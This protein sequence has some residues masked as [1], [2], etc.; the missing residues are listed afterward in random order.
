MRDPGQTRHRIPELTHADGTPFDRSVLRNK[1]TI[2]SYFQTWC[3]DCVREQPE[4]QKLQD[5]FGKDSLQV[6]MISDEAP[7]LIVAFRERFSS[8]LVYCHTPVSLKKDLGI[9][10]FPTTYLLDKK[11]NIV[12]SKVE[13]INW[14]TDETVAEISRLLRQ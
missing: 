13:G 9:R 11:G 10:A 7:E 8:K 1:V 14:Y 6:I 12:I 2:V 5:R 4:L 3:G